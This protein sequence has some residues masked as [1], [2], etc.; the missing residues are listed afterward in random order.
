MSL[1]R[2]LPSSSQPII[3]INFHNGVLGVIP[4]LLYLG[5]HQCSIVLL[6]A[7]LLL[8]TSAPIVAAI[9]SCCCAIL[10]P[11]LLL[12]LPLLLLLF[13]Y[14]WCMGLREGGHCRI[15]VNKKYTAI[16]MCRLFTW[17]WEQF[18]PSFFF[19]P[20][21]TAPAK[22]RYKNHQ[23]TA[24]GR[25]VSQGI[26]K[27]KDISEPI[28]ATCFEKKKDGTYLFLVLVLLPRLHRPVQ[29]GGVQHHPG[30]G[31]IPLPVGPQGVRCLGGIPR[32]GLA[33]EGQ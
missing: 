8:L 33:A 9:L 19:A 13:Y 23:T 10:L 15:N 6:L 31:G 30:G 17:K 16:S 29:P 18:S 4:S 12:L 14:G 24:E 5:N 2:L 27:R 7:L 28:D 11:L 25:S 26:I 3:H 1:S 32:E 20:C 22:C 21:P